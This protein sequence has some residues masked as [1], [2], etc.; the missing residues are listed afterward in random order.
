MFSHFSEIQ[1]KKLSAYSIYLLEYNGNF[2]QKAFGIS[3]FFENNLINI[4][5]RGTST[6][7]VRFMLRLKMA[8]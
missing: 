5:F 6:G 3:T 8:D 7:A 2:H 1:I 4:L